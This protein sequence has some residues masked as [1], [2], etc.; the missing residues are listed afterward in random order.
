MYD[1]ESGEAL[2]FERRDGK[3]LITLVN[4][5]PRTVAS[6]D[7]SSSGTEI[8]FPADFD[9]EMVK[10]VCPVIQFPSHAASP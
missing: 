1:N 7:V 8:G 9:A 4:T 3:R 10:N 2:V 5:H 6:P